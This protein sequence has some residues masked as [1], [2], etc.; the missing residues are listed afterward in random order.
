MKRAVAIVV[1]AAAVT[2]VLAHT[3]SKGLH[4]HITPEPAS[5]GQTVTVE[6]DAEAPVARIEIAFV[7]GESVTRELKKPV[8]VLEVELKVPEKVEAEVINC[9]AEAVTEEGKVLRAAAV[10]RVERLELE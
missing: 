7:G 9:H 4:L 1:L 6:I 3:A 5:P 10:L 8:R 2:A